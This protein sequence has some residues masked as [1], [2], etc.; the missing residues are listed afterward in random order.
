MKTYTVGDIGDAGKQLSNKFNLSHAWNSI[1]NNLPNISAFQHFDNSKSYIIRL[2]RGGAF[3][4]SLY[5]EILGQ[6][7]D[8]ELIQFFA[9]RTHDKLRGSGVAVFLIEQ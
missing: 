7:I 3:I 4:G 1:R 6:I 5:D 2:L 8:S 9:S